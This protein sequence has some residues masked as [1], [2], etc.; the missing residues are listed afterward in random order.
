M[1]NLNNDSYYKQVLIQHIQI[2]ILIATTNENKIGVN[3]AYDFCIK[4]GNIIKLFD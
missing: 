4:E 3:N 2:V 1:K